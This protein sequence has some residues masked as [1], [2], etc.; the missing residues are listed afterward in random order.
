MLV[1]FMDRPSDLHWLCIVVG[2]EGGWSAEERSM[3][4]TSA[5]NS[6]VR[7]VSLGPSILRTETAAI[8]ALSQIH[9]F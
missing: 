8:A 4:S 3:L 5:A 2:P 6:Q 7:L 9:A 1:M